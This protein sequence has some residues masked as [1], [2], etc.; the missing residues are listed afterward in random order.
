MAKG[1]DVAVPRNIYLV[2]QF[3]VSLLGF[4]FPL[5]LYLLIDIQTF[6]AIAVHKILLTH[7]LS[8]TRSNLMSYAELKLNIC[9]DVEC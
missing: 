7:T 3:V 1:W 4:T 6:A 8:S 5:Y 2:A 9:S